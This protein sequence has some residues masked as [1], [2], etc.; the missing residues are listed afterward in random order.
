MLAAGWHK[1]CVVRVVGQRKVCWIENWHYWISCIAA[2]WSVLLVT[3]RICYMQE[4]CVNIHTYIHIRSY[5]YKKLYMCTLSQVSSGV[6]RMEWVKHCVGL[7]CRTKNDYC[8]KTKRSLTIDNML[9]K[10]HVFLASLHTQDTR[11]AFRCIQ[12]SCFNPAK[13]YNKRHVCT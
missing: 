11:K 13:Q 10:T 5:V 1:V 3:I 4:L 9:S 2:V 8:T 7:R 6:C 12:S